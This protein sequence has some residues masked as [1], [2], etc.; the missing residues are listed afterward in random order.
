MTS[1]GGYLFLVDCRV[2]LLVSTMVRQGHFPPSICRIVD[3]AEHRPATSLH[4]SLRSSSWGRRFVPPPPVCNV[5]AALLGGKRGCSFPPPIRRIVDGSGT[6]P[7]HTSPPLFSLH[8]EELFRCIIAAC[9]PR[10]SCCSPVYRLWGLTSRRSGP[11]LLGVGVG[12]GV[13]TPTRSSPLPP[14][15]PPSPGLGLPRRR[16]GSSLTGLCHL[17]PPWPHSPASSSACPDTEAKS[18]YISA[19]LPPG[20]TRSVPR[21]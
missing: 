3:K 14:F 1:T 11:V 17:P 10:C 9:S 19:Q 18:V 8:T 4:R 2:G 5:V 7:H 20:I 16:I 6:L 15:H 13:K 21:Q 12:V